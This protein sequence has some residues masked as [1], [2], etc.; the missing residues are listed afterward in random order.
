[1]SKWVAMAVAAA[2]AAPAAAGAEGCLT[3]ADLQQGI[4]AEFRDGSLT[5]YRGGEA[6]LVAVFERPDPTLSSGVAFVSRLGLYDLEAA[7]VDGGE[8][9]ADQRLLMRYSVDLDQLPAPKPGESWVGKTTTTYADGQTDDAEVVYVF[10]NARDVD[11]G[12]CSYHAVPVKASFIWTDGWMMQE[13]LYL[14]A[15]G[16][17]IIVA[18]QYS[19]EPQPAKFVVAGLS[20]IT[21]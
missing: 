4:R 21:P 17:G 2:L 1:M 10:G 19:S 8:T 11:L 18:S 13:F 9:V 6:G 5:D 3:R 16:I 20:R 7:A 12:G 14:D 15:L